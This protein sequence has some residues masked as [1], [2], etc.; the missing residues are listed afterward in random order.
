MFTHYDQIQE[1]RAELRS[2]HLTRRERASAQAELAKA[3]AAQ[4]EADRAF[5][6]ALLTLRAE[7]GP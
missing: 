3:L 6:S 5:D 7:G 4:V 2:C 1:L